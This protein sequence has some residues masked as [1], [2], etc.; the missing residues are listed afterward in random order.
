MRYYLPDSLGYV[1]KK[2]Y[3]QYTKLFDNPH[4]FR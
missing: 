3:C 2:L 1:K 4:S